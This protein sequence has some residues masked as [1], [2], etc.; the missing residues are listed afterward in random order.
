MR[1]KLTATQCSKAKP[2]AKD[3]WLNDGNGLYLRVRSTGGKTWIIRGKVAGKTQIITLGDYDPEVRGLTWAREKAGSRVSGAQ[4]VGDL[5]DKY[6]AEVVVGGKRPHRRPHFV[7]GYFRRVRPA[8]GKRK[9]Q[10]VETSE[11]VE[12]IQRYATQRGVRAA[13]QLR[14]HLRSMLGYGVELGWIGRNPLQDV[15]RRVSG[16]EARHRTR[17]LDDTEIRK[18]WSEASPSARVLRFLLLTGLRIGE[19]QQGHQD[20]DRWI[21]PASISK[22]KKPHWVYLPDQ[23]KAQ[24]PLPACSPTNVQAWLR[25]WCE[26]QE[27][28]PAFTPHDTRRTA[29]TRMQDERLGAD[30]VP[31]FIVERVL[32][33]TLEGVMAV[34]NR[35]EYV[36]ERI[37]AAKK[38]ERVVLA[39]V[40]E[41]KR[42]AKK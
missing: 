26:R 19:A 13:D 15:S 39:V 18:L 33:H 28:V 36:D 37:D 22:N 29:A 10:D 30:K 17:V 34:Y 31:V 23:A 32:N 6:L 40:A 20:G 41:G 24:L 27:I 35:A 12:L 1:L 8:I 38:L 4:T 2:G 25:R 7:E 21:V 5:M 9:V 14:G 16:Y 42:R 11:L 3:R